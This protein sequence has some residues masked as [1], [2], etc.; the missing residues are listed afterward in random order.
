MVVLN[1]GMADLERWKKGGGGRVRCE[2]KT[3]STLLGAG[4]SVDRVN[5]SGRCRLANDFSQALRC[6]SCTPRSDGTVSAPCIE[7]ESSVT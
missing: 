4:R 1:E 3:V 5:R 7:K 2:E 6:R